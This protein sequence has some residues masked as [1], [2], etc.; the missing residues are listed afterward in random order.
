MEKYCTTR[1]ATDD[2]IIR[3]MRIACRKP[4]AINI[5]SEYVI[6]FVFPPQQYVARTRH[7]TFHVL[8]E[9]VLYRLCSFLQER[10]SYDVFVVRFSPSYD[11][12]PKLYIIPHN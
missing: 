9:M 11:R 8:L 4:K 10:K 7:S 5:L 3:R 12:Y 1:Q 2:S 6:F